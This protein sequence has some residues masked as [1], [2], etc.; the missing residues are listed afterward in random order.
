MNVDLP[1]PPFPE[2]I[3]SLCFVGASRAVMIEISGS[4]PLGAE[5]HIAWLGQP[6]HESDFPADSDS[7]PG[8]CSGS[9]A[10]SLGAALSGLERTSWTCSGSSREGAMIGADWRFVLVIF[11]C[12]KSTPVISTKLNCLWTNVF[13]LY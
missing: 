11:V 12:E 10:T 5:A 4:G 9:G 7:G 13:I 3:N 1:T 2:R 6:A 8:Q